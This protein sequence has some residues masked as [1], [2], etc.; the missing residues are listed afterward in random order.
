MKAEICQKPNEE[1]LAWIVEERKGLNDTQR[2]PKPDMK[3]GLDSDSNDDKKHGQEE[4]KEP[5][6]TVAKADSSD[7]ESSSSS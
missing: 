5:A 7:S 2:E 1:V 3:F 4:S 6:A